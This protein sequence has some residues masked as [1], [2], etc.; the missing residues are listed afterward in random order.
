VAGARRCE[1]RLMP[2]F[3]VTKMDFVNFFVDGEKWSIFGSAISLGHCC[4]LKSLL[5]D[6]HVLCRFTISGGY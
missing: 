2:F 3:D 6:L 4:F 1:R 5:P